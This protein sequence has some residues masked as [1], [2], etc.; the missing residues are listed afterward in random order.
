M[1]LPPSVKDLDE[2]VLFP[3]VT[4]GISTVE[5]RAIHPLVDVRMTVRRR[6]AIEYA[7]ITADI[8]QGEVLRGPSDSISHS[9]PGF[10]TPS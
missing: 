10:H 4:T 3:T 9:D 2:P 1:P 6:A 5:M 8:G 7:T